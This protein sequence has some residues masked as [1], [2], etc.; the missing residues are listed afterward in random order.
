MEF[1]EENKD[2]DL[3]LVSKNSDS[4]SSILN[5][6]ETM[7]DDED[8]FEDAEEGV[9]ISHDKQ[10]KRIKNVIISDCEEERIALPCLRDSKIKTSTIWT[11]LKDMIGKDI[12]KYSMP[13]IVNEPISIL[14]KAA[15]P[16]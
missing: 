15:E 1:D 13:V 8:D 10:M 14:Q 5:M 4:S 2:G 7:L 16:L 9:T 12:T 11:I 6:D 3:R